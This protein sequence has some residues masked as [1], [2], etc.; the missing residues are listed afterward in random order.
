MASSTE[1]TALRDWFV[2]ESIALQDVFGPTSGATSGPLAPAPNTASR[3]ALWKVLPSKASDDSSSHDPRLA[4]D[5][6][7]ATPTPE[8][9]QRLLDRIV[10][11]RNRVMPERPVEALTA[12]LDVLATRFSRPNLP[13]RRRYLQAAA[14]LTGRSEALLTER[15]D[16]A[17]RCLRAPHLSRL[18]Q[19]ELR[20]PQALDHFVTDPVSE[21]R[22][23]AFGPTLVAVVPGAGT[24]DLALL[25]VARG[26]VLK[27]AV[28]VK[29]SWHQAPEATLLLP[30]LFSCAQH[31]DPVLAGCLTVVSNL[32]THPA[33]EHT[34]ATQAEHVTLAQEV[35]A[36]LVVRH[37]SP[38]GIAGPASTPG[39]TDSGSPVQLA[40]SRSPGLPS[41]MP[42]P[43]L[44][45]RGLNVVVVLR[46]ALKRPETLR[47][48]AFGIARDFA[49]SEGD[50][51][52]G[53]RAV[54][55]EK[56]GSIAPDS[57]ARALS[58]AMAELNLSFPPVKL[59]QARRGQLR[60]ALSLKHLQNA[61]QEEVQVV[62]PGTRLQGAV[63]LEPFSSMDADRDDRT[64]RVFP[65]KNR[66]E[67]AQALDS[68]PRTLKC[69]VVAGD[70]YASEQLRAMLAARGCQLLCAPGQLYH[71]RLAWHR[72]GS[73]VLQPLLRWCDED[74]SL[75]LEEIEALELDDDAMEMIDEDQPVE[76]DLPG[77]PRRPLEPIASLQS[78]HI[79]AESSEEDWE[80]GSARTI[81]LS[82]A[83]LEQSLD[84]VREAHAHEQRARAQE[85]ASTVKPPPTPER[86][87]LD[88]VRITDRIPGRN[89][90]VPPPPAAAQPVVSPAIKPTLHPAPLVDDDDDEENESGTIVIQG[91]EKMLE[92]YEKEGRLPAN[93]PL[94]AANRSGS[95]A[96]SPSQGQNAALKAPL[97]PGAQA[98]VLPV[99]PES[100]SNSNG[101][102]ASI[103]SRQ[104][105][106]T[107]TT[108]ETHSVKN[109][110]RRA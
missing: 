82:V 83:D 50:P 62:S 5:R 73:P 56:G 3:G 48:L 1:S 91:L 38:I 34:L 12:F 85:A 65:F 6:L 18:V 8:G 16:L 24:P 21:L 2:P 45:T 42:G 29:G 107:R 98:F 74:L 79:P 22:T 64:I 104:E 55:V 67:L 84:K 90:P 14:E 71:P 72:L 9:L 4:L 94:R 39:P 68:D 101:T 27:A 96:S 77:T 31:I 35:P 57:F 66:P 81:V 49:L 70:G 103:R 54:F 110:S 102:H 60:T 11:Q 75:S 61:M 100:A 88:S 95:A 53:P 7:Q 80:D 51:G 26:L 43:G 41:T 13:E 20:V 89:L 28:V 52:W 36:S 92:A 63:I 15:L 30:L 97:P 106:P 37:S 25:A 33:L 86:R 17:L 58:D 76:E 32:E 105:L 87:V 78:M 109:S 47:G 46:A 69:V 59:S 99:P 44:T 23:R 10:A 93:S 40:A 108:T 19:R